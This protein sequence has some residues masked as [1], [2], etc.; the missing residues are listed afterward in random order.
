[1]WVA[2]TTAKGN[3]EFE[4]LCTCFQEL[5]FFANRVSSDHCACALPQH[6]LQIQTPGNSLCCAMVTWGRQPVQICATKQGHFRAAKLAEYSKSGHLNK[7][8]ARKIKI[9]YFDMK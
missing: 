5:S 9:R 7:R 1:M 4:V 3:L 2:R 8:C 6:F